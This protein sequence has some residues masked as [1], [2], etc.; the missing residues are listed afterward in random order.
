[1]FYAFTTQRVLAAML[2][3]VALCPSVALADCAAS[4]AYADVGANRPVTSLCTTAGVESG[5][6]ATAGD[7]RAPDPARAAEPSGRTDMEAYRRSPDA[8]TPNS[9]TLDT[10]VAE[11]TRRDS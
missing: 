7:G 4:A 3:I 10:I 5:C 6:R 9:L 8:G 1:M 2:M 11:R